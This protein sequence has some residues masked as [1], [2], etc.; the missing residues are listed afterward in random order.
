MKKKKLRAIEGTRDYLGEA[1]QR[2]A[3]A[4]EAAGEVFSRY[5]YERIETPVFEGTNLF[6]RSIGE[7]TDI[8]EKEMYTFKPGSDQI[9]LRPEGTAGV[10]RAYL[11]HNLHK[12]GSM[13]KLWYAGPMFRRE[14]PQKGRQRQFHQVG[15]EAVG[16]DDPLLDVETIAMGIDYYQSLSIAGTALR[17][18]SIGCAAPDC[19]PAY[20]EHLRRA[21]EPNLGA[22]CKTCQQ[23]FGRNLLR[24]LDCKNRTCQEV[25]ARLPASHEHLCQGCEKHFQVVQKGLTDLGIAYTVDGTLVRGLDYYTRTVFEYVHDKLGAQDAI[26]GGGRYDGLVQELGGP[27]TPAVGFALG[28]ERAMIAMEALG[29]PV[30]EAG[31]EVFGVA[32]QGACRER[33]GALIA[34][35]RAGGFSADMDYEGRSFKAQMRLANRRNARVVLILGEDELQNNT[36]AIKDMRE[37]GEQTT[38]AAPELLP[39]LQTLLG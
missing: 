14:R 29:V 33:M 21:I 24:I 20:R 10:I 31:I 27:P 3:R 23:R 30:E 15:V 16:S 2:F 22:L 7:A 13:A 26:G 25:I 1:Q 28:V 19:R 35:V 38:R 37:D 18:N 39:A 12:Q 34:E 9:T 32:G 36:L 6:A 11:Q 5:G 17:L 4:L 8:V